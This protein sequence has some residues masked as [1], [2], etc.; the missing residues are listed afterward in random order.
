MSASGAAPLPRLGEVFFDVR[1]SSRSMRLSWYADTDIAVFSIWQGGVCTG[2]FRL[3]MDDLARMIETLQRGPERRRGRLR[4]AGRD[5]RRSGPDDGHG[6][7]D[8][9]QADYE[10]ADYEQGGYEQGGYGSE[11][12]EQGG[13]GPGDYG[14]GD[15]GRG[16]YGPGDYAHSDRPAS[17]Y[18]AGDYD[19]GDYRADRDIPA[20]TYWQEEGGYQA[21]D[22]GR[23]RF[24]DADI[25]GYSADR[26][27]PPYV[28]PPGDSYLADNQAAAP[29]RRRGPDQGAYP[30][31]PARSSSRSQRRADERWSAAGHSSRDDYRL[32]DDPRTGARHSGKHGGD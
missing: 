1:G 28:G 3:P 19:P 24:A 32:T 7:E 20:S 11:N 4:S 26:F 23:E 13:Y 18:G 15:Y 8:H 29:H 12:Y 17:D 30:G 27:V 2:T 16:D 22:S 9:E 10:Q 25:A 5:R 31:D 21:D 6:P 14:S